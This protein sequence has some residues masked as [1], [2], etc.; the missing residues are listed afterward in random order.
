[1]EDLCIRIPLV[2]GIILKNLDNQSLMIC[3]ESSRE[4]CKY[5]NEEK[6][7]SVRKIKEYNNS[8]V[9]F[10]NIWEKVLK[11]ASVEIVQEFAHL[12]QEFFKLRLPNDDIHDVRHKRR[13]KQWHPLWMATLSGHLKLCQYIIEKTRDTNPVREDGRSALHLAAQCG[14]FKIYE[15]LLVNLSD[16][17]PATSSGWTPL[18]IAAERGHLEV[19]KLI[20]KE[21][22][23]KNPR[24]IRGFTPLHV[25]AKQG[26]LDI[27]KLIL[28][29]GAEANPT[30]DHGCTPLHLAAAKG[31]LDICKLISQEIDKKKS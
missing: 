12:A 7:V 24:L 25:A 17:N 10:Q 19:C 15:F 26:H 21:V 18:H 31:H 16:K 1:M 9:Q 30:A 11:K 20:I 23:D 13:I 29:E 8:Y 22:T 27:C 28:E 3:R 14:D 6:L 2:A 5:L 4:I